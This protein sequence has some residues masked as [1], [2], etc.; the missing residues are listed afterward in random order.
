MI[1][2]GADAVKRMAASP[3]HAPNLCLQVV[4]QAFGMPANGKEPTA[5]KAWLAEGGH[6]GPNT[7]YQVD[8]P[9]GVPGFFMKA[10]HDAGHVVL[11]SGGGMCYSTD[12]DG[13]RWVMDGRV[14]HVSIASL[15]ADGYKWLGWSET[16][17]GV[18]IH[19]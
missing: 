3:K 16:L 15:V 13:K 1:H 2:T 19:A 10:G 8:P 9:V 14:H 12:W 11:C 4:R 7:H 17:E 18:R 6:D 5:Y